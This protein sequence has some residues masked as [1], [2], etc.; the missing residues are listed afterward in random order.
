MR[1]TVKIEGND[2]FEKLDSG[3]AAVSFLIREIRRMRDAGDSTGVEELL[4]VAEEVAAAV[5]NMADSLSQGTEIA[6]GELMVN[7]PLAMA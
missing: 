7:G 1:R 3:T 6:L 5:H 2:V 4:A